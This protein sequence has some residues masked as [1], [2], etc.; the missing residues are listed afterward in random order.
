[1]RGIQPHK[2]F[3]YVKSAWVYTKSNWICLRESMYVYAKYYRTYAQRGSRKHTVCIGAPT[4]IFVHRQTHGY[5]HQICSNMCIRTLHGFVYARTI[6]YIRTLAHVYVCLY[7]CIALVCIREKCR[8]C[9]W[10]N[11]VCIQTRSVCIQ[12][13]V[14]TYARQ[15]KE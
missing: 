6:F 12:T 10:K 15:K 8:L 11:R 1:M 14:F 7:T 2:M 3:V 5:F 13:Y 9:T 4:C